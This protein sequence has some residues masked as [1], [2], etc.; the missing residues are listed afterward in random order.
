MF[1]YTLTWKNVTIGPVS[2]DRI[3]AAVTDLIDHGAEDVRDIK[4]E[5]AE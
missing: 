1:E 3:D 2:A 5:V 4:I